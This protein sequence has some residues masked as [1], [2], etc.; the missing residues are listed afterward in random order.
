MTPYIYIYTYKR[1]EASF[2]GLIGGRGSKGTSSEKFASPLL[3]IRFALYP[4]SGRLVNIFS[5]GVSIGRGERRRYL[6]SRG[7]LN[8]VGNSV[9]ETSI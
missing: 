2:G 9:A 3:L 4:P 1:E 6:S 8:S 7:E 5:K